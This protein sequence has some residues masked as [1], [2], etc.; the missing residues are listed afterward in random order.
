LIHAHRPDLIDFS[1]LTPSRHIENL[2]NAFDT[3]E[4]G[5]GIPR[6][7]D[8]EDIDVSRPD[9]KSV[10]TY[11]ASYYHTFARMKNEMKGG[12]RIANIVGQIMEADGLKFK[13]DRLTTDL[14]QWINATISKL[15]SRDFPNNLES[16]QRELQLF[17]DYRTVEKP[18]K[19]REKSEI[20]ANFF[21]INIKLK[22][23]NQNSFQPQ[24]GKLLS[25]IER[26]W[27]NL[28][29]SEYRRETAL[30][31]ELLRQ[32]QLE[33]LAFKFNKKSD[34]REGYLKDMIQVL[35][36]PRYGVNLGQVEATMKKH[37]AISADILA[38]EERCFQLKT[39]A[40]YL[41]EQNYN[42]KEVVSSR[43]SQIMLTWDELIKLL[44]NHRKNLTSYSN[45]YGLIRECE[46]ISLVI[47]QI[48]SSM[49]SSFGQ[50]LSDVDDLL[51]KHTLVESQIS[52][53]NEQIKKISKTQVDV[54]EK[55]ILDEKL[56]SLNES[57]G[58]LVK[59]SR[60]RREKLEEQRNYFSFLQDLE[61]EEAWVKE[62]MRITKGKLNLNDATSVQRLIGGLKNIQDE[63]RGRD[64]IV[65]KLKE[66][67]GEISAV[68]AARKDSGDS[69]TSNVTGKLNDLQEN[70]KLLKVSV[71]ERFELLQAFAKSFQ[72]GINYY[73]SLSW[74]C[75][76]VKI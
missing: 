51:Q 30:K 32:T 50:H 42:K 15:N 18:P 65:D 53:I 47:K 34:L 16:I 55:L 44:E 54:K 49:D 36:D 12:R 9:E 71:K 58:K 24:D 31:K 64:K 10:L 72:V 73:Q 19:Y 67:A 28:E 22:E 52:T 62:K 35:S 25:D 29:K 46:T 11:V 37:E 23:L 59:I 48:T 21:N 33:Q 20:E 57:H 8:A 76:F 14:L 74:Q 26:A 38:R 39:M 4:N 63:L 6:L 41:T 2:N 75:F 17:K 13:Y 7:L 45:L 56:A 40:E 69:P 60:E 1:T 70:V 68:G 5:L 66:M 3:A 43:A 61:E 27:E